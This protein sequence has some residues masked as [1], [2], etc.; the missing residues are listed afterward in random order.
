MHTYLASYSIQFVY[1]C[2]AQQYLLIQQYHTFY[3]WNDSIH[4]AFVI[5]LDDYL[6][7]CICY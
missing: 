4:I 2:Y 7:D 1:I 6:Q 5:E 3:H